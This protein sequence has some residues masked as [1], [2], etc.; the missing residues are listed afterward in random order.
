MIKV[1]IAALLLAMPT[2]VS[3]GMLDSLLCTK[4]ITEQI[5]GKYEAKG[6][7]SGSLMDIEITNNSTDLTISSVS[8]RLSGTYNNR[9]FKRVY[10]KWVVDVEPGLGARLIIST[11]FSYLDNVK[12]DKM[13]IYQIFGC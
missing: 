10:D 8:V 9:D 13:K 1:I 3:A 2:Q 4:D 12:V 6:R 5:R 7:F 11:G